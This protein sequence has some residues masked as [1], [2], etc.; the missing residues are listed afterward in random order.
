M[1][2]FLDTPNY[3]DSSSVI[4]LVF[5]SHAAFRATYSGAAMYHHATEL[6]LSYTHNI[7]M[8][9]EGTATK[10]TVLLRTSLVNQGLALQGI[11]IAHFIKEGV[12]NPTQE[13]IETFLINHRKDNPWH[14][15]QLDALDVIRRLYPVRIDYEFIP[16]DQSAEINFAYDENNRLSNVFLDA[17]N[18]Q[19]SLDKIESLYRQGVKFMAKASGQRD[20]NISNQIQAIAHEVLATGATLHLLGRFGLAH[21]RLAELLRPSLS[22]EGIAVESFFDPLSISVPRF[23][24]FQYKMLDGDNPDRN[25]VLLA[26]YSDLAFGMIKV[27]ASQKPEIKVDWNLVYQEIE[28]QPISPKDVKIWLRNRHRRTAFVNQALSIAQRILEKN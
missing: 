1:T 19:S 27:L 24:D 16:D 12:T 20:T 13:D 11:A 22:E 2:E 9:E 10:N 18:S 23:V 5:G 21:S 26:I 14:Y 6:F 17:V 4:R 15:S 8:L 28:G 25:E 3:E 7:V